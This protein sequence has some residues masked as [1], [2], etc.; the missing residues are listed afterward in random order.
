MK[1][2]AV[3]APL[4]LKTLNA[5]LVPNGDVTESPKNL[6]R[7]QNDLEETILANSDLTLYK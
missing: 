5:Q 1:I 2:W 6:P 4:S 3:L 7:L